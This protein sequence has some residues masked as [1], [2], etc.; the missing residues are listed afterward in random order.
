MRGGGVNKHMKL[1]D[2]RSLSYEER[3]R[4]AWNWGGWVRTEWEGGKDQESGGK[5]KQ[6][7]MRQDARDRHK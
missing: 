5:E 2:I 1:D 3:E 7:K 6:D 4:P